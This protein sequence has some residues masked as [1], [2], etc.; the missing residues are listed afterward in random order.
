[1]TILL[2]S[3]GAILFLLLT[4][5][6]AKKQEEIA[7]S[8]KKGVSGLL[9]R[10]ATLVSFVMLVLIFVSGLPLLI[11]FLLTSALML[12]LLKV[13]IYLTEQETEGVGFQMS[14]KDIKKIQEIVS[15]QRKTKAI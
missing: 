4:L 2:I 14:D 5:W 8:V 12:M 6:V 13:G 7:K 9:K 11:V 1:M 3:F 15:E 10:I